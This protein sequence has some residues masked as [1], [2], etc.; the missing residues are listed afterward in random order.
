MSSHIEEMN[1]L[2]IFSAVTSFEISEYFSKWSDQKSPRLSERGATWSQ[3]LSEKKLPQIVENGIVVKPK[4]DE[5]SKN[6]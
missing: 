6:N 3:T 4:P 1:I 2:N 5:N